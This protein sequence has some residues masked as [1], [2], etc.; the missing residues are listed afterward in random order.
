M[1][2]AVAVSSGGRAPGKREAAGAGRLLVTAGEPP[3]GGR[4]RGAERAVLRGAVPDAWRDDD[5]AGAGRR[6][7]GAG[8][9]PAGVAAQARGTGPQRRDEARD[10]LLS[11]GARGAA[12]VGL[13]LLVVGGRRAGVFGGD[14][15]AGVGRGHFA[16]G[17]S[18]CEL[19]E[20]TT[21]VASVVVSTSCIADACISIRDPVVDPPDEEIVPV[22]AHALRAA[23]PP[24]PRRRADRRARSLRSPERRIPTRRMELGALVGSTGVLVLRAEWCGRRDAG[25][26]RGARQGA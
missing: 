24:S 2:R 1:D 22:N 13:A 6:V 21:R 18:L 23:P 25:Q 20:L 10:A 15:G 7:H 17:E 4:D 5:R 19:V 3:R 12:S 14:R 8:A 26:G 16:L 11:D 9:E